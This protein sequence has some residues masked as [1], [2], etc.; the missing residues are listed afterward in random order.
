M[1][2]TAKHHKSNTIVLVF[3]APSGVEDIEILMLVAVKLNNLD[4]IIT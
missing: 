2:P 4:T 1:P 3:V